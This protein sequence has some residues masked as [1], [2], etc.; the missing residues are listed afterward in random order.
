ME[1]CLAASPLTGP[2]D[3]PAA[4]PAVLLQAYRERCDAVVILT[5]G[6]LWHRELRSNRYHYASRFAHV[7]PTYFMQLDRWDDRF[8]LEPTEIPGLSLL[9]VPHDYLVDANGRKVAEVALTRALRERG[10]RRPLLWVYNFRLV[11]FVRAA[12]SPLKVFHATEHHFVSEFF[13]HTATDLRNYVSCLNE[14]D[15]IVAV[16][17]AIQTELGCATEGAIPVLLS[18]NGCDYAFFQHGVVPDAARE[19]P[20]VIYQGNLNLRL[21]LDLLTSIVMKMPDWDFWLCGRIDADLAA[22]RTWRAL[23]GHANVRLLGTLTASELRIRMKQATVGII[24]FLQIPIMQKSWPLKA[25]EYIACGLPVVSI[26]IDDLAAFG[27]A[28]RFA[29]TA[30]GFVAAIRELRLTRHDPRGLAERDALARAQSYDS[31]FEAVSRALLDLKRPS[32]QVHAANVLVLFDGRSVHVKTI[33][34]H[35]RAVGLF[36]HHHVYYAP[37]THGEWCEY[38]LCAFDVI[39]Q[40]Y[41]IRVSPPDDLSKSYRNAL[42]D[43][44]GL[45]VLFIQDEYDWTNRALDH[46]EELGFQLVYTCVSPDQV[47][48][49]YPRER[50]SQVVFATTLTG[51]VPFDHDP[52][53]SVTPLAQRK[54]LIGY[55]GRRLG[56]WYGDLGQEK[57]RIGD[58]MRAICDT[59]GLVTDIETDDSKRIYGDAWFE[60]LEDSRAT[61]G[62]ESGSNLFD[63]DGQAKAQV[64]AELRANPAATYAE[65]RAKCLQH[66]E[67]KVIMNQISP[68][69]FEAIIQRTALVLF[70]GTY[71]GIVQPGEH[72]IELKKDFSNVDEVLAKVQD[73]AYLE[74][75][76]E[77]AYRDIVA[78]G[79]YTYQAMVQAFDQKLAEFGVGSRS[80][81]DHSTASHCFLPGQTDLE[82]RIVRSD[83]PAL[84]GAIHFPL[85]PAAARLRGWSLLRV[86]P[87]SV[88]RPN[89]LHWAARRVVARLPAPMRTL[90]RRGKRAP[91][92]LMRYFAKLLQI[93]S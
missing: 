10:I 47:H 16:C 11:E 60:F 21:D 58:E 26:P 52:S 20:I 44:P 84:T 32:S 65:I 17:S 23:K 12:F 7:L 68:K 31:R 35:L 79:R 37:A 41:C 48:K 14:C 89:R 34:H 38:D 39:V 85:P 55:R 57:Q 1:V 36:S 59:R 24:P 69:L 30:D 61:L 19:R 54:N 83:D 2:H 87:F 29:T 13:G 18:P 71:S 22:N 56:Y 15:A 3:Q 66:L 93:A 28:I 81:P 64:E 86:F 67:G 92:A 42:R 33:Q 77:R 82:A 8:A 75:L 45:K 5:M 72:F 73:L 6:S 27:Q 78:S 50:F 9:H 90:L 62:T 25:F 40:H 53:R 70:E 51:Y 76:A 49:V 4:L 88:L 63:F 74:Q 43:Y 91:R 46:I 80:R